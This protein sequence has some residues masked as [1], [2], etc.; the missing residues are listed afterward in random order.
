MYNVVDLMKEIEPH[1]LFPSNLPSRQF[2]RFRAEGFTK[3]VAGV[4]FRGGEAYK[5]V[6]LG[7]IGTGHIDLNSD[8][9]LGDCTVFNTF[10][11][12]RKLSTPFLAF[13]T[14][15]NQRLWVL[16]LKPID[17]QEVT[18]AKQLE[19]W[20]HYPI[21]DVHFETDSAIDVSL[22]AY[23][24]FLPGDSLNS[25][26]PAAIFQVR[27]WNKSGANQTGEIA[28]SFPGPLHSEVARRAPI[29]TVQEPQG[30]I[31]EEVKGGFTGITVTNTRGIGY[32]LGVTGD[33]EVR[34]G[35]ALGLEGNSWSQLIPQ[36]VASL[37]WSS[38][39]YS[40]ASVAVK[41]SLEPSAEKTVD[42]ILAWYHPIAN[43]PPG[44]IGPHW[45]YYSKRFKGPLEIATK[46]AR[47]HK[48]ILQKILAW[49]EVVYE[50]EDLPVWLQDGLV[51]SFYYIAKCSLWFHKPFK[52]DWYGD[53]GVLVMNS[54]NSGLEWSEC[55]VDY[56]HGHF[57]VLL[58]FPDLHKTTLKAFAHYQLS[59]GELP[60]CLGRQTS[61]QAPEYWVQHL[62]CAMAYIQ[63]VYH[64]YLCTGD[65]EFLKEYYTSLKSAMKYLKGFDTD[66][67]DLI[68]E[69][70]H[71]PPGEGFPSNNWYESYVWAG[72]SVHNAGNWLGTLK[73]A[74]AAAETVGDQVYAEEFKATYDRG[75]KAFEEKLWKGD[76][77][78][79]YN[80]PETG[81]HSDGILSDQLVGEWV[82]RTAGLGGIHPRERVDSV[83]KVLEQMNITEFGMPV[84]V[85]PD[86]SEDK[87]AS[88]PMQS[89]GIFPS[90]NIVIAA[91]MAYSGKPELS[92]EVMKRVTH[93]MVIRKA[94]P[95]GLPN[96]FNPKTGDRWPEDGYYHLLVLW[97]LP[98][99]LRGQDLRSFTSENG[100]VW[101]MMKAASLQNTV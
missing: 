68:N 46:V 45:N 91:I 67:D 85:N 58:F 30:F 87:S 38:I 64:Q 39:M 75:L 27:A 65:K 40:G 17:E 49:Q 57:G 88:H 35:P 4:I 15:N 89:T 66:G 18:S 53:M 70:S 82:S 62:G 98:M 21:A 90:S 54:A 79:L 97:T 26:T 42:F 60:F 11:P 31:R 51:N 56:W 9:T 77:Y 86:R 19:Y 50:A 29:P 80:D 95:W 72:T 8:G 92:L 63:G 7:G 3:P 37:S 28:L 41:Y 36:S 2:I 10:K 73:I 96:M 32:S 71:A 44:T 33:E 55:L 1:R 84:T 83:H 59:S 12:R 81:R 93:Y 48:S 43:R 23:S 78:R 13:T 74:A 99:A 16:T 6:P 14:L 5:G 52:D 101:R 61:I 34:C 25:N 100:L 20:G 76:Y 94:Y 47:E 22:R 24:P 69:H